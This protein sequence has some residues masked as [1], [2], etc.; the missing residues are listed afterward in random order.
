VLKNQ[1]SCSLNNPAY[2]TFKRRR[3]YIH[4]IDDQWQEDLGDMQ[5]YI[6]GNSDFNYILTV[7]D[8]F[9]KYAW[10]ISLQIKR[11]RK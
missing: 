10:C 3:V 11:V 5:Q 7:I 4:S 2:H 9:S 8:C 1:N 6:R